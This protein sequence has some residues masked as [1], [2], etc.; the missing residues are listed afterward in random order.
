MYKVETVGEV[1]LAVAGAP[2]ETTNHYEIAAC[3]ALGM[4]R[5]K[6]TIK[7]QV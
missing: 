6:A 5:L 1:Y 3:M 7:A 4:I 2:D